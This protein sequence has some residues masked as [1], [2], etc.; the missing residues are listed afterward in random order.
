MALTSNRR[1][2]SGNPPL[3]RGSW[4][5]IGIAVVL[6]LA[7]AAFTFFAASQPYDGWFT[8]RGAFGRYEP[9]I[10]LEKVDPGPSPLEPGDRLLA[11]EGIPFDE[12]EARAAR[13][14]PFRP[15]GWQA[16]KSVGYTV[17]RDGRVL[18]VEV[19]LEMQSLFATYRPAVL[20]SDPILLSFPLVFLIGLAVFWLRPRE[21]AAQ[22]LF[23]YSAGFFLDNLITWGVVQPGVG[24]LFH[25]A[26]YWP[27]IVL[28]N[29]SWMYL[30]LP[31][32]LHLFLVFPVR[33]KPIARFP[34][35]LPAL[36]YGQGILVSVLFVALSIR[37]VD[38]P[39]T[40]FAFLEVLPVLLLCAASLLHSLATVR[41]PLARLQVRWVVLGSM[42]GL[43][44]P[45]V[46]WSLLGGLSSSETAAV[47]LLFLFLPLALPIS[48]AVAILRYRLWDIEVIIRRTL[49]YSAL[50]GALAAIYFGSVVGLQAV[51]VSQSGQGSELAIVLSTLAIAAL[52]Q[53]LRGRIQR[54]IDRAF[55][56]RKYDAERTL[57]LLAVQLR[58]EVDQ[59]KLLRAVVDVVEKTVQPDGVSVWLT[60]VKPKAPVQAGGD[61]R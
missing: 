41:D 24:D 1:G 56:R 40:S 6:A 39:G 45:V 50:S 25:V 26:N 44:G 3:D 12:L 60:V 22:L 34:R 2:A 61:T 4:I 53:P 51:F 49:V 8:D 48:L 17:L 23:L 10:F 27:R 54:W 31:A 35:L 47:G 13:L 16:G 15:P 5:T 38:L 29:L 7:Q 14:D 59:E 11:V 58:D 52:F 42:V 33:K 32:M 21:A 36:I 37:G 20:L 55:Y 30:V 19:R 46:L 28:G 9:I 57:A 43:L 18:D